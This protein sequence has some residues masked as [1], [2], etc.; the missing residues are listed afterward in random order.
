MLKTQEK[1]LKNTK[2][3]QKQEKHQ[4][5]ENITITQKYENNQKT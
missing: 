3:Y 2:N 1:T 5:H 4:K